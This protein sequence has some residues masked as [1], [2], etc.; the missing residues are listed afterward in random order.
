MA[1][2]IPQLAWMARPDGH[3][4]WYNR[5]WYEYNR[6]HAGADGG[7]GLAGG[8][9]PPGPAAGHG[10]VGNSPW[11]GASPFDM[12]FPL[13]G[14]DGTFRPVPDPVQPAAGRARRGRAVVRHEHRRQRAGAGPDGT[15]ERGGATVRGRP[16]QGR[17]LGHAGPRAAQPPGPDP[18]RGWRGVAAGRRR[19]GGHR[20]G[21]RHDGA[22]DRADDPADRR[23]AGRL[24]G[25]PA[26]SCNCAASGS[27]WRRSC[28]SAVEAVRPALDEAGHAF[29]LSLPER[30]VTLDAD[31]RP[32]G[33]SPLEPAGQRDQ[34]H[35]G[36]RG[37]WPSG[38]R[39]TRTP[40][41]PAR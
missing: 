27:S 19:P 26:A 9:R 2:S 34:V 35:P 14:A 37:T 30:P 22:A 20:R 4:F 31:A 24:P 29:T 28:G 11:T 40:G 12:V 8:A 18:Q 23:S 3:I 17:V 25:S 32:A 33:P 5:R 13:K 36:R 1:D 15:A 41:T 39:S 7:L 6:H 38:P 21:P 16:P 10:A